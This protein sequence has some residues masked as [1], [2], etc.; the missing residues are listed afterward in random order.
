MRSIFELGYKYV[1]PS[2]MRMLVLELER[3]GMREAEIARRL[4]IPRSTVS[5]YLSGERGG[6]LEL[7]DLPGVRMVVERLAFQVR[8]GVA[9]A[10]DVQLRLTEAVLHALAV[11]ALCSRHA[12]LD[13]RLD[14]EKCRVCPTLFKGYVHVA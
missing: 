13:S 9:G 14:P 8:E 1:F 11:K 12:L 10:E 6:M 3:L 4:G 5:R 2:V 7:G